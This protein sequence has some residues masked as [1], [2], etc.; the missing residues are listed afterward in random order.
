M[1]CC[2]GCL[3]RRI[4]NLS[5]KGGSHWH[6]ISRRLEVCTLAASGGPRPFQQPVQLTT[7][8]N[9]FFCWECKANQKSAEISG[10]DFHHLHAI[11]RRTVAEEME[12]RLSSHPIFTIKGVSHFNIAQDMLHICFV[13]GIVNKAIGS[14]LKEWCWKDGKGAR[15]KDSPATRLGWIF[16]RIQTLYSEFRAQRRLSNLKL[17]MFVNPE[18]PHQQC[19][20]LKCKGAECKWLTKIFKV[21]SQELHDGTEKSEHT[22]WM[23]QLPRCGRHF[24]LCANRCSGS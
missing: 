22:Q 24:S 13:H 20:E 10:F 14:A 15:Q 12:K 6:R 9:F 8:E 5:A 18:K 16:S 19:P 11:P 23:F 4:C 3:M 2:V 1:G 17:K 21:I 7:L